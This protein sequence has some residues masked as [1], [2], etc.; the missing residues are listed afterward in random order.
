VRLS[1]RFEYVTIIAE[2]D[3]VGYVQYAEGAVITD[4]E[5]FDRTNA[6]HWRIL[7]AEIVSSFAEAIGEMLLKT[8]MPI[9]LELDLIEAGA[10][11]D[12]D[13]LDDLLEEIFSD[14]DELGRYY[15][16]RHRQACDLVFQRE[17]RHA[18][19]T[20]AKTLL[21]TPT[22]TWGEVIAVIAESDE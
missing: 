7:G 2:D 3:A 22:L 10:E 20:V 21:R 18:I 5:T 13:D 4:P 17:N 12:D 1:Q 16:E 11:G 6:D 14:L 9:D 15:H 19:V 8:D